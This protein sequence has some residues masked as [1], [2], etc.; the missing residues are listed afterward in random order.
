M[1]YKD[2]KDEKDEWQFRSPIYSSKI[3][4]CKQY[5]DELQLDI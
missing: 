4:F 1:D 2:E 3:L 5:Q